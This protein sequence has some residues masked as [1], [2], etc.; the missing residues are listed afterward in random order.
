[1]TIVQEFA[2]HV[3]AAEVDL[4]GPELLPAR[5]ARACTAVLPIDGAGMSFFFSTDRRVP[6][7]ASDAEAATAERLQFTAGEGPCITA[8]G[9]QEIVLADE[10]ELQ[11]RWPGFS[12]ALLA[13]TAVR[14]VISLPLYGRL[15]GIGALDLYVHES[16]AVRRVGLADALAVQAVLTATF[17]TAM[18]DEPH[19]DSGPS[20]LDSPSAGRR[21][22]VWQAVGMTNVG[23]ELTSPDALILLRSYAYGHGTDLDAVAAAVVD[24][25]LPL[26]E[27][28]LSSG[29]TR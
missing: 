28:S 3:A 11:E 24:R 7:G 29:T 14:G 17:A 23:L 10:R 6:L 26:G 21:A 27:L 8:H 22:L 1:L 9:T 13:R 19:D 15:A 20:W 18:D 4:P 2:A 25:R 16:D 5:L 12:D